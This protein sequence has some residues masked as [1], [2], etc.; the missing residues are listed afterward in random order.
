VTD[1]DGHKIIFTKVRDRQRTQAEM[2][3]DSGGRLD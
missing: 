1:A 3:A 2:L